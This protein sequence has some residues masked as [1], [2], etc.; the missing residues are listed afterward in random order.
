MKWN[1]VEK[2]NKRKKQTSEENAFF[3]DL[4]I[5]TFTIKNYLH[6]FICYQWYAL[7]LRPALGNQSFFHLLI[8]SCTTI[9]TE[10]LGYI[11]GWL[12]RDIAFKFSVCVYVQLDTIFFCV[13]NTSLYAIV[14]TKVFN[15]RFFS[16][17][18]IVSNK[19]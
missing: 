19:I 7:H 1:D 9:G 2:R 13:F 17:Y 18:A 12:P 14:A 16:F 8:T 15:Q 11:F 5:A 6:I 3:S 10:V 4:D